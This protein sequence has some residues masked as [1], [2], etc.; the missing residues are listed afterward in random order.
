MIDGDGAYDAYLDASDDM[1]VG[2]VGFVVNPEYRK[3]QA[4]HPAQFLVGSALAVRT[5]C[6]F[7]SQ[8]MCF[9]I[10]TTSASSMVPIPKPLAYPQSR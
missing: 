3:S 5:G 7:S 10:S 9:R 8:T 2:D 4:Y 6:R 1:D